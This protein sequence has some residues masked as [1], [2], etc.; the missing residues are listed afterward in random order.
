[1]GLLQVAVAPSRPHRGP[2]S[3]SLVYSASLVLQ[4]QGSATA[5]L[6]AAETPES[7]RRRRTD[8]GEQDQ[9]RRDRPGRG[10]RTARDRHPAGRGRPDNGARQPDLGRRGGAPRDQRTGMDRHTQ[11]NRGRHCE[12]EQL[13]P[14]CRRTTSRSK[15]IDEVYPHIDYFQQMSF[16]FLQSGRIKYPERSEHY[17]TIARLG[18]TIICRGPKVISASPHGTDI[19]E[20]SLADIATYDGE[21]SFYGL[22]PLRDSG[23]DAEGVQ[24]A[25]L[26]D[27]AM[28]Y[29]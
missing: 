1:M 5:L 13:A 9:D 8:G 12:A 27:R 15:R 7:H 26:G 6:S 18:E 16:I 17:L 11:H 29:R 19:F 2:C 20:R 23:L 22:G 10:G 28:R 21:H 4:G 24:V 3:P 25:L 14:R